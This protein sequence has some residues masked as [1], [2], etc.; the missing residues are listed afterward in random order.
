MRYS[1]LTGCL[2]HTPGLG[3]REQNMQVAQLDPPSNPI[4]PA[5]AAPLAKLLTR[6]R[7]LELFRYGRKRQAVH[8]G[9]SCP[10]ATSEGRMFTRRSILLATAMSGGC[11]LTVAGVFWAGRYTQRPVKIVVAGL[12]GAPFDL[13]ARAIAE[14][15]SAA[16]EQSFMVENRRGAAGN[17]G[18]EAV[19]RSASDGHTLPMSL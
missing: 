10:G 2:G 13:V 11:I 5:H 18:A 6:S 16:L 17:L 7:K 9:Q 4:I 14:T 19:V 3:H 12:P 15:L 8:P 1:K